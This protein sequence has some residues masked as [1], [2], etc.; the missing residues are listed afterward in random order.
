MYLCIETYIVIVVSMKDKL[1][2]T[3]V[4]VREDFCERGERLYKNPYE[5]TISELNAYIR[6]IDD[7]YQAVKAAMTTLKKRRRFGKI[8]SFFKGP[9]RRYLHDLRKDN[10]RQGTY[11]IETYRIHRE[12]MEKFRGKLQ[13]EMLGIPKA[14]PAVPAKKEFYIPVTS[15]DQQEEEIHLQKEEETEFGQS[16]RSSRR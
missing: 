16:F 5:M 8:A 9:A 13:W 2:F 7:D 15:P 10:Y 1:S 11:Y 14:K 4:C 12:E 3:D 6:V